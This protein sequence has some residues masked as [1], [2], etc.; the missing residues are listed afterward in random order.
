MTLFRPRS[1]KKEISKIFRGKKVLL[2]KWKC[3]IERRGS[4]RRGHG[5]KGQKFAQSWNQKQTL[6]EC[7]CFYIYCTH[8]GTPRYQIV[9]NIC[10]VPNRESRYPR[11]ETEDRRDTSLPW[12][13]NSRSEEIAMGFSVKGFNKQMSLG[14]PLSVFNKNSTL[15]QDSG[16]SRDSNDYPI[17]GQQNK[18][19]KATH[20]HT[21]TMIFPS[22]VS[23]GNR[24]QEQGTLMV[25]VALRRRRK[26]KKIWNVLAHQGVCF[27][28]FGSNFPG[29]HWL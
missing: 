19:K 4:G 29:F 13:G 18:H 14:Y 6:K 23:S 22:V 24:Q 1:C 26:Q 9:G 11:R 3:L 8:L 25:L 12:K 27:W 20:T 21:H 2:F 15:K 16:N 5:D 10:T 17:W 7:F 28:N